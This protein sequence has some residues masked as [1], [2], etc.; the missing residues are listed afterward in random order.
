[1]TETP[2]IDSAAMETWRSGGAM[3][4]LHGH[5]IFTRICGDSDAPPLL[6]LHGFPTSSL[7]WLPVWPGLADR[8]RPVALD[9]LGYGFSDKPHPHDYRLVEQANIVEA[10]LAEMGIESYHIF[11]HD[12]GVS[13][14]QELLARRGAAVRSCAFLNGGLLPE[15]H[16]PRPIQELLAG[17]QGP[18]IVKH[19]NCAAF[20]AGFS[21]V[22]GPDTQPSEAELDAYW[23]VISENDGQ[24]VQPALLA[25][26]AERA[27][28]AD[29]WRSV[30][31]DPP[32]PL[33]MINGVHDPVSGG[34]LADALEALNPDIAVTR[35]DVGHYPQVEAP[36]AVLAAYRAFRAAS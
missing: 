11:A 5:H 24:R 30:L 21:E 16:R 14:A 9:F 27:E 6:L 15:Q 3:M 36:E 35:L 4:E 7:D 2:K 20:G 26:M 8:Y 31:I 13:V 23:A 18:E 1:M 22:F 28:H 29:R 12:Y 32:C 25:Y 33:A 17:P 10:L 34:H 19:M